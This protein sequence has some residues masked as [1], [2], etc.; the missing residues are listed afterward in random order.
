MQLSTFWVERKS[1]SGRTVV[2][3]T[4][5]LAK[6]GLFYEGGDLTSFGEGVGGHKCFRMLKLLWPIE[7][8]LALVSLDLV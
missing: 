2:E 3:P 7:P 4:V 1:D 6:S 8:R 5:R